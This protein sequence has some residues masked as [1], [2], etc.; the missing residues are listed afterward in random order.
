MM[1]K[2]LHVP[3]SRCHSTRVWLSSQMAVPRVCLLQQNQLLRGRA[4]LNPTSAQ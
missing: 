3:F 2:K 1:R 4:S